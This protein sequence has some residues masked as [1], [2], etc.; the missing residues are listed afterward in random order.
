[1]SRLN[2]DQREDAIRKSIIDY[3]FKHFEGDTNQMPVEVPPPKVGWENRGF[4]RRVL[5]STASRFQGGDRRV[6][7]DL[8]KK[9]GFFAKDKKDLK[10]W[11]WWKRLAAVIRI[12]SLQIHEAQQDLLN[13]IDDSNDLVAL[14]AMRGVSSLKFPGKA[15]KI[16]DALSRRAPSRR[17]VLTDILNNLGHDHADEI[18]E[19]LITCYDPY[20]ASICIH[21]LGYLGIERSADTLANF[22][23]SSDDEVVAETARSLGLLKHRKSVPR[24]RQLLNHPHAR[25][26]AAAV[27][28][29]A[30]LMDYPSLSNILSLEADEDVSVRRAVFYAMHGG[31]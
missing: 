28:S 31:F 14:A 10:S 16:L 15:V 4:F 19:Y 26:R 9:L 22:L 27:E 30:R 7:L 12:E 6:L 8:Y 1:M 2:N 11:F 21:V 18:I 29:L 13:L 24:I 20:I 23:K 17:D 5:I 25:V 3:Y